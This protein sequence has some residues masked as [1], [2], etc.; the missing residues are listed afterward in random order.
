MAPDF[1][2]QFSAASEFSQELFGFDDTAGS[3]VRKGQFCHLLIQQVMST[4]T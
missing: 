4:D 1:L 3:F 2:W